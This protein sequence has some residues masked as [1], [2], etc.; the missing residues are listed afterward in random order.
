MVELSSLP[1]PTSIV[2]RIDLSTAIRA[3]PSLG[4]GFG[5]VQ[6]VVVVVA[7][8][9]S[10]V[11]PLLIPINR[12]TVEV[13]KFLLGTFRTAQT[14]AGVVS[15]GCFPT[16]FAYS[17]TV[18]HPFVSFDGKGN[19][20]PS[21]P[22][23]RNVFNQTTP[24]IIQ[25]DVD[26]ACDPGLLPNPT[27]SNFTL[28]AVP[29]ITIPPPVFNFG[30]YGQVRASDV[31]GGIVVSLFINDR[32]VFETTKLDNTNTIFDF[33]GTLQDILT[34]TTPFA[35]SLT[36]GSTMKF[37][38]VA[39]LGSC[40]KKSNEI[41][42]NLPAAP[43]LQQLCSEISTRLNPSYGR[44]TPPS[45]LI[46]T[47]ANILNINGLEDFCKT[48][49]TNLK[50][51]N[52]INKAGI[53]RISLG[54]MS[55]NFDVFGGNASIDLS[56]IFNLASLFPTAITGGG[57]PTAP[58]GVTPTVTVGTLPQGVTTTTKFRDAGISLAQ[59]QAYLPT[60]YF[61]E[62]TTFGGIGTYKINRPNGSYFYAQ[63]FSDINSLL[64]FGGG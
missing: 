51:I 17:V 46:P 57:L 15:I 6:N 44:I 1:S 8:P 10:S 38:V 53:G 64:H 3:A 59:V 58:T 33:P 24:I 52:P 36:P 47:G 63:S 54:S 28:G 50:F 22:I 4:C 30:E 11:L 61:A 9:R 29:N 27:P 5:F 21:L 43:T 56:R 32:K 37:Y 12:A 49:P 13:S 35:G 7:K 19:G 34:R 41:T 45:V 62:L 25:G 31:P 16:G 55:A 26:I 14:V 2:G 48:D 20:V 40:S 39:T 60:G 18:K 42:L 23:S